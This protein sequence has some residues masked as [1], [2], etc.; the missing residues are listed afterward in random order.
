MR[1]LDLECAQAAGELSG[2]LSKKE[3]K[4][5]ADAGA[6]LASQGLY[7]FAVYLRARAKKDERAAGTLLRRCGK[8]V[9]F[10]EPKGAPVGPKEDEVVRLMQD[11]AADL[12]KLLLAKRMVAETLTYLKY[13]VK[14][15]A[16][17]PAKRAASA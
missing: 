12:Q 2:V 16:E 14:S 4:L 1:R 17:E 8:L 11:I 6:V 5:I 7:A 13:H 3:E 15:K 9:A 10:L